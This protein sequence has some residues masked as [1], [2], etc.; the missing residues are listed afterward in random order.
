MDM[1][2]VLLQLWEEVARLQELCSEQG[3]LLQ[4]LRARKG[5]LLGECG[6]PGLHI[7]V[8]PSLTPVPSGRSPAEVKGSQ[9]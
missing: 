3:R 5:P 6:V 9:P 1:R 8:T 4:R 7:W 2:D